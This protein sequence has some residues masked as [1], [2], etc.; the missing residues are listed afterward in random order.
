MIKQFK[1]KERID[2]TS[3]RKGPGANTLSIQNQSLDTI[4]TWYSFQP[5]KFPLVHTRDRI[6][7]EL[8]RTEQLYLKNMITM[9]KVFTLCF[10]VSH[11]RCSKNRSSR[12]KR[13]WACLQTPFWLSLAIAK[14]L[15]SVWCLLTLR[16]R[17]SE[18]SLFGRLSAQA[19]QVEWYTNH[20]RRPRTHGMPSAFLVSWLLDAFLSFVQSLRQQLWKGSRSLLWLKRQERYWL[21]FSPIILAHFVDF[22]EFVEELATTLTGAG[23]QG[24]TL[25]AFLLMPI[26]RMYLFLMLFCVLTR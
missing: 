4:F 22:R 6:I 14:V 19:Q 13:S 26:Q 12:R 15:S 20:W 21:S 2:T 3:I 8:L 9:L 10:A 25:N 7:D 11:C 23:T 17:G 5:V 1:S 18:P 16:R 24:L